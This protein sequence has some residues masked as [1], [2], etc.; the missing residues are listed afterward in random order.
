MAR[1]DEWLVISEDAYSEIRLNLEIISD[2]LLSNPTKHSPSVA[3][4]K[5]WPGT[6]GVW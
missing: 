3:R 1:D 6:C 5:R 4:R 2:R